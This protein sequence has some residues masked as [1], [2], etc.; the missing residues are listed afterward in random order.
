MA[1]R[2]IGA[3]AILEA[4]ARIGYATRGAVYLFVGLLAVAAALSETRPPS[5]SG[6]LASVD[7][8]P[9]GWLLLLAVALGMCALGVWRAVQALLDLRGCGWHAGGLLQRAGILGEAAVY[10]GLGIL[11]AF[12]AL[13]HN[14]EAREKSERRRHS[15]S[16]GRRGS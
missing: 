11:A 15:S 5:M 6:A 14:T 9:G 8:L 4:L 1:Q 2:T 10:A 16:P 3:P 13:T 12:V 7:R